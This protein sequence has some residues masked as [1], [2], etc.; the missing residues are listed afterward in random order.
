[1]RRHSSRDHSI[2]NGP[3]PIGDYLEPIKPLS[4]MVSEIFNGEYDAMVELT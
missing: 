2:P 3:F 4:L 1:M